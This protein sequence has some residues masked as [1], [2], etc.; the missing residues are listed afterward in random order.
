LLLGVAPCH[1]QTQPPDYPNRPL[2]LVV[3]LPPGGSVDPVARMLA[4][5]L[6]SRLAQQ[7]VVEN[8][9]GGAG[10]IAAGFGGSRQHA[11]RAG[12]HRQARRRAPGA[13]V[14]EARLDRALILPSTAVEDAGRRTAERRSASRLAR[15]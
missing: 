7:V 3:P 2:R 4:A 1:A 14:R 15:T 8:L 11:G 13:A 10:V 5:R 9:P 12:G 6:G